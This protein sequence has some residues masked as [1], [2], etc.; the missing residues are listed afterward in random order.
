MKSKSVGNASSYTNLTLNGAPQS[1]VTGSCGLNVNCVCC[2]KAFVEPLQQLAAAS[3]G[4]HATCA[5][6]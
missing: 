3:L 5:D 2:Q 6:L 4:Q 1:Y